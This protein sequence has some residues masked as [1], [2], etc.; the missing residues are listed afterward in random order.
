MARK[1]LEEQ[2]AQDKLELEQM[3]KAFAEKEKALKQRIDAKEKQQSAAYQKKRTH[4][5]CTLAPMAMY[6]FGLFEDNTTA[7]LDNIIAEFKVFT[8][9]L[10]NEQRAKLHAFYKNVVAGPASDEKQT[11]AEKAD[12]VGIDF[13]G[14]ASENLPRCEKCGT[15]VSDAVVDYCNRRFGGKLLCM[16]CQKAVQENK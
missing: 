1:T 3:R 11:G 5:L 8:E 12:K 13:A 10:S 4:T 7:T 14:A 15:V 6:A 9:K 2:I 16:E